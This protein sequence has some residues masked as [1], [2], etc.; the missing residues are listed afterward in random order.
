MNKNNV[1]VKASVVVKVSR[2]ISEGK[3]YFIAP[4]MG[5]CGVIPGVI[6]VVSIG[7]INDYIGTDEGKLID[8]FLEV[9]YAPEDYMYNDCKWVM[10]KYINGEEEGILTFPVD[11]FV[12]HTIAY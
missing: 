4:S 2:V 6:E 1:I 11:L 9:D 5:Y 10:Y 3:K 7:T 8:T 12:D